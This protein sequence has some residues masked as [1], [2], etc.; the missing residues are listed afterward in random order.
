MSCKWIDFKSPE[1][2]IFG[3]ESGQVLIEQLF[4]ETE[5][6]PGPCVTQVGFDIRH[7][8]HVPI[9]NIEFIETTR[10]NRKEVSGYHLISKTR[11]SGSGFIRQ[12][13]GCPA[14]DW[15]ARFSWTDESSSVDVADRSVCKSSVFSFKR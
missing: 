12:G 9:K 7:V 10:S 11:D 1:Q 15:L 2:I 5:T 14:P 13:F 6:D 3:K 8:L 4:L